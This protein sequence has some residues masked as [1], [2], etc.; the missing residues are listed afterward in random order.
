M[1]FLIS[2]FFE[3][4]DSVVDDAACLA[5]CKE[6]TDCGYYWIGSQ[7]DTMTCRLSS[8]CNFLVREYGMAGYLGQQR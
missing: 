5:L 7:H 8:G 2:V 6:A 4:A 1:E 3:G